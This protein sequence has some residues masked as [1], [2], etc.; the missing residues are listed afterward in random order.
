MKHKFFFKNYLL[1][2]TYH[3]LLITTPLPA[4]TPLNFFFKDIKIT[5]VSRDFCYNKM[6]NFSAIAGDDKIW[7]KRDG[8]FWDKL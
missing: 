8:T 1:L 3:L 4:E 5:K 6:G 7:Q 2:T